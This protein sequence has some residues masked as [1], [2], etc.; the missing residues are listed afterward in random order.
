MIANSFEDVIGNA[1]K[2]G[3]EFLDT[4]N[5]ELR[6]RLEIS[7]SKDGEDSRAIARAWAEFA[8]TPQGQKALDLLFDTTLRRTV[9]FV[10]LGLDPMSM[11]NW[12]AFRE[13]Q[14]A[15]AQEIARQ[16]ALG[17]REDVK[18]RDVI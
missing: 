11:A 17:R 8:D 5:P 4:V 13:G 7:Q 1:A 14:N 9:Y 18:P 16:V 15:L 12:G 2:G 3:F 6:K 10:A